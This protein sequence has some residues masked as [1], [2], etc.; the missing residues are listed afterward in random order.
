MK[1]EINIYIC[2]YKMKIEIKKNKTDCKSVLLKE[3]YIYFFFWFIMFD[4][5]FAYLYNRA[6]SDNKP[7]QYID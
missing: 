5:R 2:K 1:I 3:F 4:I 7:K 6:N